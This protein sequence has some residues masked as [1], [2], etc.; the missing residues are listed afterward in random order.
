MQKLLQTRFVKYSSSNNQEET[1]FLQLHSKIRWPLYSTGANLQNIAV[2]LAGNSD[3]ICTHRLSTGCGFTYFLI[4]THKLGEMIQFEEH[5]DISNLFHELKPQL[6]TDQS[7]GQLSFQ[8]PCAYSESYCLR[9]RHEIS[10]QN[11]CVTWTWKSISY[12]KI[13]LKYTT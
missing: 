8:D 10:L 13:R 2:C 6:V 7:S 9:Q 11:G 5:I 3:V 1:V 4:F 12:W